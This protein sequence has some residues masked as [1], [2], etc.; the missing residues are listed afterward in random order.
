MTF[1]RRPANIWAP[2]VGGLYSSSQN[3]IKKAL[4]EITVN[5]ES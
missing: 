5:S 1:D 3:L 4:Y 2:V